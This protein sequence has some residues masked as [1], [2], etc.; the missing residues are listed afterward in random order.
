MNN[1]SIVKFSDRLDM[2]T[3]KYT[4][5][6]EMKK[7]ITTKI[8][9]WGNNFGIRLPR[10]FVLEGKILPNQ[11]L[12]VVLSPDGQSFLIKPESSKKPISKEWFIDAFKKMTELDRKSNPNPNPNSGTVTGSN[13]DI[14]ET[15]ELDWGKPVGREVW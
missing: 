11:S 8:S 6:H 10:D 7:T 5:V 9:A 1:I 15:G 14:D 2:Y 13:S 12:E 3:H 4:L